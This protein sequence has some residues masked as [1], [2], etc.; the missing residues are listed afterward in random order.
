MIRI[1]VLFT[2]KGDLMRIIDFV[3]LFW[4]DLNIVILRD[5]ILFL[6]FASL[7]FVFPLWI[8]MRW[9][10]IRGSL[11]LILMERFFYSYHRLCIF[12][13]IITI[14]IME[15]RLGK[16]G[17]EFVSKELEVAL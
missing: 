14:L 13:G 1:M 15:S 4:N 2:V 7:K 5:F 16:E 11:H 8:N 3:V 10:I 9:V 12:Q 6:L 17:I